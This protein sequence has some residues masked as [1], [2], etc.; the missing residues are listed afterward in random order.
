[1]GAPACLCACSFC[2]APNAILDPALRRSEASLQRKRCHA[3]NA[4]KVINEG[5]VER[6]KADGG[7]SV[8]AV[9]L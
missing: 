1:M 5:F 9:P 8:H 6:I 4:P 7:A 3:E 2:C